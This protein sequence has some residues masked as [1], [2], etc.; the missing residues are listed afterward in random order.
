MTPRARFS[1]LI[2]VL[3]DIQASESLDA[4]EWS[5][6][7]A[8]ARAAG[9][10]PR[11]ASTLGEHG[12]PRSMPARFA[13][14]ALAARLQGE[15]IA[16]DALREVRYLR[17]ALEG[18]NTPIVLLKGAAYVVAGLPPARGRVFSDI[19]IL[20]R[21]E[22]LPKVEASLMMAGWIGDKKDSYDQ[23]YY[24]EWSHEIPPMTHLQ[25]GTTVD[26]HH[27]LVMPTCRLGIDSGI[28]LKSI[29][30]ASGLPGWFRL[31]DEAMVLHA[32][33]HLLLNSEFDRG[34]RDLGDINLLVRH[35][36]GQTPG[37]LAR[38]I[39]LA[40]ASGLERIAARALLLCH[41]FYATPL[42]D[43]P[44]ITQARF[45][46]VLALL[47][48]VATTRHPDTRPTLQ[49]IADQMLALR[50]LSL[51]FPAHILI[52]HLWHKAFSTFGQN[53]TSV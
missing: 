50:E 2:R 45:D 7:F 5:L 23:R 31:G 40:S 21:R 10:A 37:F 29:V 1:P 15:A 11:I 12:P 44:A 46:P 3:S 38:L 9:L 53:R 19:D 27:S 42:P 8:E 35:F 4:E 34:L 41:R 39:D 25:R 18:I 33:A 28:L 26:L 47:G 17:A 20:S 51:R 24:R 30:P 6:L 48:Q 16:R 13:P 49:P 14:Q 36:S 43:W 32:C 52:R 22:D